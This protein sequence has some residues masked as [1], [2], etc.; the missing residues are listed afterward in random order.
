MSNLT[1]TY[2]CKELGAELKITEANNSNGN[3]KGVLSLGKMSSGVSI[4]Y[5]F[6]NSTGP[7]TTLVITGINDDPNLYVGAA[8]FL[9][10][11]S[12]VTEITLAGGW[13]TI[14]EAIGFSSKFKRA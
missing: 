3:G 11:N 1:G 8:G 4:H 12:N 5:H 13:A 6:K 7:E 9:P 2:V 10:N 14:N